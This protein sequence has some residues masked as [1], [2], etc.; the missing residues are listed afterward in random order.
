MTHTLQVPFRR[1]SKPSA[2]ERAM[3]FDL[4]P[5]LWKTR[6]LQCWGVSIRTMAL[7]HRQRITLELNFIPMMSQMGLPRG[8]T[9]AFSHWSLEN[10]MKKIRLL[11]A[12]RTLGAP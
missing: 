7:S 11:W 4:W 6:C 10:I 9:H 3:R 8:H 1:T 12:A 2:I 5:S